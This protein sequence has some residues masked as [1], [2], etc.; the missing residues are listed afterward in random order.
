MVK[1]QIL[2]AT[3]SSSGAD[4]ANPENDLVN[5]FLTIDMHPIVNVVERAF[6]TRSPKGYGT[7]LLLSRILKV[8]Q[9]FIS[10][11]VLAQRLKEVATY[12]RLCGF[13]D[14]KVPAHNTYHTL[15]KALGS[16]GYAEIHAGFLGSDH[17]LNLLDP[18]LPMLPKN[19]QKGLIVIAY[20]TTIRAYCST[21][22]T[23][24][25]DGTWLF[26]DSSVWPPP[27]PEQ[28]PCR[29]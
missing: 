14:G 13:C 15:R 5:Y 11:R 4:L 17:A 2:F 29:R 21:N 24:H 8:K 16:Q 9:V 26:T 1:I 10:D 22:G 6:S 7:S 18:P 3:I 20:S 28:V 23:K 25:S 19:R 27:S 12:R